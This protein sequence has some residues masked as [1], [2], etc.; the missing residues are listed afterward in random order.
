MLPLAVKPCIVADRIDLSW[1]RC[2]RTY[3]ESPTFTSVPTL[4]ESI[5]ICGPLEF[6]LDELFDETEIWVPVEAVVSQPATTA[7]AVASPASRTKVALF[8]MA[9]VPDPL[10][11]ARVGRLPVIDDVW[12]DQ[13]EQITLRF[14]AVRDAE[15]AADDRQ[16]D[17]HR[18]TGLADADARLRQSAHHRRFAVGDEHFVVDA[19]FREHG[20][21]VV[22]LELDVRVLDVDAHLDLMVRRDLRR[23]GEDHAGLLHLDRGAREVALVVRARAGFDH[24][25]RH[26]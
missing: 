14:R 26:L 13:D 24:A 20:A 10:R 21:D 9:V 7:T 5:V 6:G 4:G 11:L 25:D 19:L 12:C 15:Q 8:I 2:T 18:Q 17:E 23:H 1:C 22:G 16:V 3:T